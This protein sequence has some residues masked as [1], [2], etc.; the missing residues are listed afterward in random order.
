MRFKTPEA[1][2][3][4]L[5]VAP[6]KIVTEQ[7]L[8]ASAAAVFDLF[9]EPSTWSDWFPSIRSARWTSEETHCVGATRSVTLD[10]MTVYERFLAWEPGE[11]FTF[12]FTHTSL[13]C[14]T[15][16]FVE[17]YRLV[18]LGP[19]RCRLVW[20]VASEPR[21]LL[22]IAYRSLSGMFPAAAAGLAAHLAESAS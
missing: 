19:D 6:R 21:L 18:P 14:F 16:R 11:R 7:E 3:A 2:L 17:D 4:F 8:P 12:C 22:K 13:P 15:H 10:T 9:A 5:D 20:T 1:D